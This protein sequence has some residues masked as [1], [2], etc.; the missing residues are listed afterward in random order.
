MRFAPE[1][2]SERLGRMLEKVGRRDLADAGFEVDNATLARSQ[3]MAPDR[4]HAIFHALFDRGAPHAAIIT[5]LADPETHSGDEEL[6]KWVVAKQAESASLVRIGTTAAAAKIVE[7]IE[8]SG[9]SDRAA[10]AGANS[11]LI[12]EQAVLRGAVLS[13][14]TSINRL[15]EERRKADEALLALTIEASAEAKEHSVISAT[16]AQEAL[17]SGGIVRGAVLS[18]DASIKQLAEERRKADEVAEAGIRAAG[19]TAEMLR[20]NIREVATAGAQR[21]RRAAIAR[22]IQIAILLL[23]LIALCAMRA[24]AQSSTPLLLGGRASGTVVTGSVRQSGAY[25]IDCGPSTTFSIITSILT[26]PG[27]G[28]IG[29][30]GAGVPNSTGSAW[31]TSYTVGVAANNLVQLNGSGQLPAVSAAL[32]TSFPTVSWNAAG[33]THLF[34]FLDGGRAPNMATTGFST[35]TSKLVYVEALPANVSGVINSIDAFYEAPLGG[36]AGAVAVYND[37]GSGTR[38]L[39][40]SQVSLANGQ[41]QTWALST[42]V[43]IAAGSLYW[44][45][46]CTDS[47][48]AALY[49]V[50]HN[51]NETQ[52]YNIGAQI[53][54]ATAANPCTGS[55][56]GL[57][58][59][60][61]LGALTAN[62]NADT[63]PYLQGRP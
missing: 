23:I 5:P 3:A 40:A 20:F 8:T 7:A 21:D 56:A 13:I 24:K 9:A 16:L 2:I 42:T 43:T 50:T 60:S 18:I 29:Y 25:Y 57:T 52:M 36:A 19:R 63:T 14:D 6:L 17:A 35:Y 37:S 45:A 15:A 12:T 34:T 48:T 33:N 1:Q 31:G 30:P 46:W 41:P 28:G 54:M 49:S 39:L 4:D 58:F 53:R 51:F 44:L 11:A 22:W 32:L 26:C 10:S 47:A 59:P 38:T 27:T 61:A 62:A 55:G